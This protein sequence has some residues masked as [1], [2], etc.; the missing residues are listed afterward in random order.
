MKVMLSALLS[1]IHH[2]EA[3]TQDM[4][5]LWSSVQRSGTTCLLLPMRAMVITAPH[6]CVNTPTAGVWGDAQ[7]AGF[8][9]FNADL[10]RNSLYLILPKMWDTSKWFLFKRLSINSKNSNKYVFKPTIYFRD[11]SVNK[12][13]QDLCPKSPIFKMGW[14]MGNKL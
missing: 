5:C 3:Q 8:F 12:I 4:G 10:I 14:G 6:L 1:S 7:R 9:H 2:R 11:S 13:D